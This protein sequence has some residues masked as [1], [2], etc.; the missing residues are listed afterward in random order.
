MLSSSKEKKRAATALPKR[1]EGGASSDSRYDAIVVGSGI[2]GLTCGAFLARAGLKVLVLETHAKI[3]GYAHSFKRRSFTFESAIHSVPMAGHGIVRHMLR[4]LGVD[5]TIETIE[6]P[7]M[8]RVAAPGT[9]LIM[10]SRDQE[11][12][13]SLTRNF[14]SET[15][16][17]DALL[18]D[19]R[20]FH[21]IIEKPV[22][23]FEQ[24]FVPED[25]E[26]ASKYHN[27]S[28]ENYLDGFL[29]DPRLK[30]LFGGQWPYGGT[31][32][33]SAPTL[34]FALMYMLHFLEGSHS[35]KGGF[36]ML[37]EALAA[38]ITRR[39][40]TVKTRSKV[41]ELITGNGRVRAARC[42]SG[43]EYTADLFVSNISPYIVHRELLPERDRS[44]LFL[45]RL[46]NLNPS[47]SSVSVYLGMKPGFEE[48]IPGNITFW[49]DHMDF[50]RIYRG[51]LHNDKSEID[52]LV[53]LRSGHFADHPTLTLMNFTRK[54]CSGNW[55][56]DKQALA[57]RLLAKMAR[58]YP[59]LPQY[60]ELTVAGSPATFERY[61]ANTDGALYGFENTKNMYGEAKIPVRTHLPN[62]Y[63]A[64]HW[65]K[66]GGGV[67]NVMVNSY[68]TYHMIRQ[69][70]LLGNASGVS[71]PRAARNAG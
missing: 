8:Y 41:V 2:G 36:A 40:G 19:M 54:D 59:E 1:A 64:G 53:L 6:L 50:S 65:G 16:D 5:D 33:E 46:S 17:I 38:A 23:D 35:L 14:P 22:F 69:D 21:E 32:P 66:P 52:H 55:K 4:L 49:F 39:G 68:I 47:V 57:D 48:I 67:H 28:Y 60:V 44:K 71:Y 12:I 51:I 25:V 27:R 11:I 24:R 9:E 43:E 30:F 20:R 29:R 42:A 37:A 45:R 15:A 70:H 62:L 7:E 31:S 3:G 61:T 13:E 63:Q 10:P 58:L 56:E 34:F 26:F 18:N